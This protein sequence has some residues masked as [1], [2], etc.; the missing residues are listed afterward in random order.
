MDEENKTS[1][2]RFKQLKS[3]KLLLFY[4]LLFLPLVQPSTIL[5]LLILH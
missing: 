4:V 2:K 1:V 5:L 3:Y